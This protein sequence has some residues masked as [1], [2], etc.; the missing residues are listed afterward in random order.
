MM[1]RLTP[2]FFSI[3]LLLSSCAM[4]VTQTEGYSDL[5]CTP[6]V[7]P[8]EKEISLF[9]ELVPVRTPEKKLQIQHFEKKS[10][11]TIFDTVIYY[12]SIGIFSF[13]TVTYE[14]KDDCEEVKRRNS[15]RRGFR[16]S[17][18]RAKDRQQRENHQHRTP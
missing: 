14:V 6:K 18:R 9:W 5:N 4:K 10:K 11:R 17:Y 3:A 1:K 15:E 12:G 16:G 7:L 13:H 2:L 8:K